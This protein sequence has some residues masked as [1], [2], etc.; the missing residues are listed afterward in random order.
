MVAAPH[1][2]VCSHQILVQ[3]TGTGRRMVD[4]SRKEL[5]HHPITNDE[6]VSANSFLSGWPEATP[7]SSLTSK[8]GMK[9]S[10]FRSWGLGG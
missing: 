10:F 3:R 6:V 4:W 5:Y 9:G 7:A 1:R 2:Q 8:V